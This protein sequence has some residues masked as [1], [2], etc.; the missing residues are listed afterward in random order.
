VREQTIK[1]VHA[2]PSSSALVGTPVPAVT[3]TCSTPPT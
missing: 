1:G 3:S 2:P